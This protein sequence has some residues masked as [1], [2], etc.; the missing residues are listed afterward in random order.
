[1]GMYFVLDEPKEDCPNIVT[2]NILS[3]LGKEQGSVNCTPP[4]HK[5]LATQWELILKKGIKEDERCSLREKYHMPQNCPSATPSKLN[6]EVKAALMRRLLKE[7]NG[8]K[9][10]RLRWEPV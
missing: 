7:M 1:M 9:K 3:I 4:I 8:W 5:E 10:C 2:K 6:L